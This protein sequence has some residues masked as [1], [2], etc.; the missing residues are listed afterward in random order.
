VELGD[1]L[2]ERLCEEGEVPPAVAENESVPGLTVSVAAGFTVNVTGT[3]VAMPLAVTVMEPVKVPAARPVTT[4]D[5]VRVAGVVPVAGETFSHEALPAVAVNV[6]LGE[7]LSERLCEAGEVPPAGAEK[8]SVPGL[9]VSVGVD[10][11]LTVSVTGML[12]VWPLPVK[13]TVPE[14]VPA[15]SPV[16]AEDTVRV[17]GVAPVAGETFSHDAPLTP[18]VN[19]VLGLAESE[20]VFDAGEAPSA[21]AENDKEAGVTDKVLV[22]ADTVKV[23]GTLTECSSPYLMWMEPL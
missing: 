13:T 10:A 5:T 18:A 17:A 1:P 14:N 4:D 9:T 11:G 20:S 7:A 15:A 8:D 12:A 19:V 6:A 3:L 23:T 16:M 21:V 22:G 2:T